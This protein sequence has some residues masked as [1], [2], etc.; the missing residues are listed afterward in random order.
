MEG[1]AVAK[2]AL[3]RKQAGKHAESYYEEKVIKGRFGVSVLLDAVFLTRSAYRTDRAGDKYAGITQANTAKKRADDQRDPG[4]VSGP[5]LRHGHNQANKYEGVDDDRPTAE[6]KEQFCSGFQSFLQTHI[7][8]GGS[9][10]PG[11]VKFDS[12]LRLI[13]HKQAGL[14]LGITRR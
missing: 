8:D 4:Q 12:W 9:R 7:Y 2:Q 13:G 1:M 14:V 10:I 5:R 11:N 3:V 6:E